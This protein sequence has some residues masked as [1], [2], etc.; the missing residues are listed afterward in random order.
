MLIINIRVRP[1]S[2]EN[3][4][5]KHEAFGYLLSTSAPAVDGKAN[6]AVIT[7]F[8]RRLHISASKVQILKGEKSRNKRLSIECD[9]R[10]FDEI[11]DT[12]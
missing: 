3:S 5:Q 7:F 4:L 6:K 8:S 2:R 12:R 9:Q 11:C 1:N 10:S